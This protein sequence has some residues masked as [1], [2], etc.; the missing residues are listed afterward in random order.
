MIEHNKR[1]ISRMVMNVYPESPLLEIG[2]VETKYGYL[3]IVDNPWLTKGSAY[4]IEELS[5]GSG[6][7]WVTRKEKG[8]DGK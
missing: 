5:K 6:F 1:D 8:A 7:A 2:C 4:I 3:P